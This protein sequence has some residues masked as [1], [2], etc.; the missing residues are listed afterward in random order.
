MEQTVD[1]LILI[2]LAIFPFGKLTGIIPD[3]LVLVICLITLIKYHKFKLN[4]FIIICLF[5]LVYSLSFFKISQLAI[6]VL[7]LVR[8]ISYIFLSQIVYKQFGNNKK[9]INLILNSLIVVGVFI[10]IFG[11][12]QYLVFPDLRFLK[13]LGWDDHYF[14]LASTFLDPAFTG[15]LVVLTEI[16]IIVKTI[17]KKTSIN[18]LLNLFFIITILFTYSRSSYLAFLF[19]SI[20]LFLKFRKRF[21]LI[22]SILFLL[23]IFVLPKASSEGTNLVRTYSVN[24]KFINYN[25]SI[26]LIKKSP[27]FGIGFNNLCIAK[28]K[29][30]ND[31][32]E[33]SHTCS[34]LDNSILF[35]IATTGFIGL[36]V[37]SQ[38]IIQIIKNTK[39]DY[40]GWG[41]L[42]SF[43]AIFIHGMFTQTFFYNF[44]LGWIAILIGITRKNLRI[45]GD[46]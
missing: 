45:K 33:Q 26:Q 36:I 20:F 22:L 15:I 7:Y 12:I 32:N 19:S 23:L 16:L 31:T 28:N 27:F 24:Q 4:N 40:F 42:A 21:I 37:F 5:S 2:Y 30:M 8:L 41:L 18:Y 43:A 44:I 25:E 14:R 13:F 34:G 29:F 17:Q 11:W 6:G 9:K 35:I 10:S 3:L 39:L 46:F 1:G 38:F